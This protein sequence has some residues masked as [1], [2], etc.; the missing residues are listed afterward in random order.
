MVV[1]EF[2]PFGVDAFISVPLCIWVSFWVPVV[3]VDVPL[4][5]VA[6]VPAG[7]AT[8]APGIARRAASPAL[9]KRSAAFL[10]LFCMSIVL[11]L[12]ISL[13]A[14]DNGWEARA[15]LFGA[16]FLGRAFTL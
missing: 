7:W 16:M 14:N 10:F 11:R 12:G 2:P 4:L 9:A 13:S 3:W 6:P 15:F 1:D 5:V 8:A